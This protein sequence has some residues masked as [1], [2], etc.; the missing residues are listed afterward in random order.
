MN[1]AFRV[2]VIVGIL[3]SGA[4][5][6]SPA[7]RI[8]EKFAVFQRLSTTEQALIRQGEIEEGFTADMVYMAL[9]RP[10]STER[11]P[12]GGEKWTYRNYYPSTHISNETLYQKTSSAG[13]ESGSLT[14]AV[15]KSGGLTDASSHGGYYEGSGGMTEASEVPAALME[16]WFSGG[17]VSAFR[18]T[19]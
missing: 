8:Q 9:G 16:V 19:P 12:T 5:A 10:S 18:L 17:R 7:A 13:K 14:G 1:V 15:G 6:S 4:C 11:I 2:F 3:L